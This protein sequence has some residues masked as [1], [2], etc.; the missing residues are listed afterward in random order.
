MGSEPKHGRRAE[1]LR[2]S[3]RHKNRG[4]GTE[5]IGEYVPEER[6][7]ALREELII[8]EDKRILLYFGALSRQKNV[9]LVVDTCLELK[10]TDDRYVL[11][12]VGRG[13]DGDYIKTVAEKLGLRDNIM[14]LGHISDRSKLFGGN[15]P[16]R[17]ADLSVPRQQLSL[18][19]EGGGRPFNPRPFGRGVRLG[20]YQRRR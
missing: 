18:G 1:K 19:G 17:S 2:L 16:G 6:V 10:E 20:I 7:E 3:R 15:F 11:L 4:Q 8:P 9:R 13:P 12:S 14:F 5:F